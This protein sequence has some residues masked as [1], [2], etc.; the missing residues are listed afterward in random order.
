[1]NYTPPSPTPEQALG[2][3][4]EEI[5]GGTRT[6]PLNAICCERKSADG[7]RGPPAMQDEEHTVENLQFTIWY[8]DYCRRFAALPPE[9]QALSSPPAERYT[10]FATPTGSI[11]TAA[12][13]M[14]KDSW[15]GKLRR[16]RAS[17]GT[18]A[19]TI[20]PSNAG[21][22]LEMSDVKNDDPVTAEA[23]DGETKAPDMVV[24]DMTPPGRATSV[25][26]D[27]STMNTEKASK[28]F[29]ALRFANLSTLASI[30]SRKELPPDTPLPFL[31][32]IKLVTSTF[33]LPGAKKE[34]N[35][36]ARLRRHV[37][38][39][40]RPED[41]GGEPATTH[42]D[43]FREVAD[44][45]YD[46]LERSLPHYMVWSKGN[47]N[48]PKRLFWHAIGLLDMGLGVL[49]AVI[50]IYFAHARWWRIFSFPL[51]QFGMVQWYAAHKYFCSQVFRRGARQLYPWELTEVVERDPAEDDIA[52]PT[53]KVFATTPG[54]DRPSAAADKGMADLAASLPFL[55]E[56][57]TPAEVPLAA[58]KP[59]RDE[60][61][62]KA[63]RMPAAFRNKFFASMWTDTGE[64]VPVFGPERALEDPYIKR[65]H[66]KQ[67]QE[68]YLVAAVATFVFLC[69]VVAIP[70]KHP[71]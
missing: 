32:E 11:R 9:Y 69:V 5:I 7:E 21:L 64:R 58:Q 31:D 28:R 34:L 57:S 26:S 67:R 3:R 39:S 68:I 53:A 6:A 29:P 54:K 8:R 1:M 24:L 10:A 56:P 49:I 2:V 63:A 17:T 38:K 45:V 40:L 48:T 70:E 23:G 59:K 50:C 46:L 44:H 62:R 4:L 15:W 12:S 19:T 65:L 33:I 61:I 52:R 47:T 25:F 55:F 51:F 13:L 42:P 36:D 27:S 37:L 43:V 35:I 16:R 71:R 14:E 41:G 18:T 30:G 66:V 20:L 22:G 60:S